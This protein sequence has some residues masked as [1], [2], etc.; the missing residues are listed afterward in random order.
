MRNRMNTRSSRL[1]VTFSHPFALA[2]YA[3]ELPAGGYEV[4]VEEELI[5][6]LSFEAYRTTATYLLV[7]GR[8]GRSGRTEL[9]LITQK[10]L[11]TAL[12]RDSEF[13]T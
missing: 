10:D 6:G 8:G 13:H 4:I 1:M 2:G 7:H 11:E 9:R 12:N 5:Q 3:D